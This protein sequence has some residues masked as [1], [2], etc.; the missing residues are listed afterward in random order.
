MQGI[1][2]IFL[3]L[4]LALCPRMW[5]VLGKLPWAAE[6]NAVEDRKLLTSFSSIRSM[7]SFSSRISLLIFYLDNLSTGD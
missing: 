4:L 3:C 7:V 6:K 1:I 5:S 2:S